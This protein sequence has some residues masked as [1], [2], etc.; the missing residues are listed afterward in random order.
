MARKRFLS[1][2]TW[3]VLSFLAVIIAG[4]VLLGL[5]ASWA[6]GQSISPINACFLATSAVCVTGLSP[7][8]ISEVLSPFGKGVLLC[9]IQTGGLGVMTYTSII[10]L[11]WR[12]NVPFNSREAVSQALLW[13]DFSL[14]A[15]LRQVLGLVFGIEAVAAFLL[16]LHDPVFFYPFS[17]V[18]HAVSAFCNAGFAL[19]TTN[20]ALFRDDVVVNAVIASSVVLGG[21]GFGVLREFLGI[22]T[23]GAWRA[24]APPQPLQPSGGENEPFNYCSWLGGHVRH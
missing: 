18:F 12:N 11:L 1:P 20:L 19:S 13:G 6:K 16:W 15:F 9:L 21:I 3:P 4:S 17:A 23:G 10:F 8:D 22:C 5:P 14:A 24:C 7:L 2:F